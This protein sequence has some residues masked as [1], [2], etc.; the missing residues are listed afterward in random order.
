MLRLMALC[1]GVR[2]RKIKQLKSMEAQFKEVEKALLSER[3]AKTG[4]IIVITAG[5]PNKQGT[6]R[7]MRLYVIGKE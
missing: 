7:L 6:T 4:D 3:L 1:W 2:A 5:I